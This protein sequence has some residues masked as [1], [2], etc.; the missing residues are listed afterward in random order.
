VIEA[1][2]R[3]KLA[4]G[5]NESINLSSNNEDEDSEDRSIQVQAKTK[6][7]KQHKIAKNPQSGVG[8]GFFTRK[9][10]NVTDMEQD[11]GA[12]VRASEDE[13]AS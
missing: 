2:K 3:K 13:D 8:E 7:G 5:L 1:A 11:G 6:G 12:T 4:G 9:A 10:S